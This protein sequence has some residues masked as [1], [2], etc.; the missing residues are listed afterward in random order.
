MAATHFYTAS[1]TEW[2][3]ALLKDGLINEG[4]ACYVNLQASTGLA[5]LFRLF[6]PATGAH[7][8][9]MNAAERDNAASNLGYS[10]E[11][12]ACYLYSQQAPGT[13]PLYR[14]YQGSSD[15]HFYTT[16]LAEHQNAVDHLGYSDEGVTGWVLP[17]PA[18]AAVPLHRMYGPETQTFFQN[19][20]S[21]AGW[22]QV[23]ITS[24]GTITYSGHVHNDAAIAEAFDFRTRAV[25]GNKAQAVLVEL[26]GH[27]A[28]TGGTPQ[29]RNCYW[30]QTETRADIAANY[31]T[32]VASNTFHVYEDKKG[33]ITGVLQEIGTFVSTWLEQVVLD[34]TVTAIDASSVGFL[35]FALAEAIGYATGTGPATAQIVQGVLWL[36][37]PKGDLFALAA[38]G[39]AA[40]G[41]QRRQITQQEYDWANTQVFSGTLPDRARI[42][43]TD[44]IG[45]GGRS[46][47][48]PEVAGT[49]SVNI[50]PHYANPMSSD[51]ASTFLHEL[52][53]AWQIAHTPFDSV[54]MAQELAVQI[55]TGGNYVV[56]QTGPP[57]DTFDPE[58]QA[59]IV[60]HWYECGRQTTDPYYIY[61]QDNIQTGKP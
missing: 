58:A 17:G 25:V 38:D 50:G 40:L 61:I 60:Q 35:A 59:M 33:S 52:T 24:A 55:A 4:V 10:Y 43:L 20:N 23:E 32:L 56:G 46:F 22:V 11:G 29:E 26:S 2:Q 15:D 18:G 53:H 49:I 42:Y 45:G 57:F 14:A 39:L 5:P 31:K 28:G 27:V 41:Q 34:T 36:K 12:I 19:L 1:G 51:F 3:M 21:M 7:F 8:Y 9:T 30:T 44:T 6:H 16:N 13:V 47:T 37:G 48:F 54:W